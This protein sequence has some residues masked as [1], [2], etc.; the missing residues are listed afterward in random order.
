MRAG[1]V[2]YGLS[3]LGPDLA[4]AAPAKQ[5]K[6]P[7][8]K[9]VWEADP[10]ADNLG[11]DL[12]QGVCSAVTLDRTIERKNNQPSLQFSVD[13]D[14]TLIPPAENVPCMRQN[15][16]SSPA[17]TCISFCNQTY[18]GKKGFFEGSELFFAHSLYI[19]LLQPAYEGPP[20]VEGGGTDV[21]GAP[22]CFPLVEA[23]KGMTFLVNE[24]YGPPY[25]G[26][27]GAGYAINT[28]RSNK[29]N[30]IHWMGDL[31]NGYHSWETDVLYDQWM[32]FVTHIKFS[33]DPEIG[34]VEIWFNGVQQVFTD[35]STRLFYH[36]GTG[37]ISPACDE[38]PLMYY[39]MNYRAKAKMLGLVTIHFDSRPKAGYTYESVTNGSQ[40]PPSRHG[41]H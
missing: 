19:P 14:D 33:V 8:N 36:V 24:W 16:L 34:F 1:A 30:T 39:L 26:S 25:G 37:T 10:N 9:P 27:P 20:T 3:Q 22:G 38:G 23:T 21:P 4:N 29:K 6:Q 7:K 31:Y 41:P 15:N 13:D 28:D 12:I 35:G 2:A 32:D 11:F 18:N 5:P 40:G 17:A